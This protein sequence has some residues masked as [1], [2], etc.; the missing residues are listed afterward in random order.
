[1]RSREEVALVLELARAG[2]HDCEISRETASRDRPFW[3]GEAGAC[4]TSTRIEWRPNN[5][6]SLSVARRGSVALLDG[7]VGPNG[8]PGS[9]AE[10]RP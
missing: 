5:P 3:I 9:D 7:F 10:P 8:E 1:M 2:W 4:R 6:W